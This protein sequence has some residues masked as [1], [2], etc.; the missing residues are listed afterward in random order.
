MNMK[1]DYKDYLK[2]FLVFVLVIMIRVFV[3]DVITVEGISMYPT[4]NE[5]HDKVILEKYKQFT[6][7]YDR[8]DIVV[9]KLEN[10]NIIKR[11]IGLPNET[12]EIK[13]SDVYINGDLFEEPYLDDSIKT[14]P[15]MTI[16]I[17]SD[18]IFVMGDNRENS[19]DS[20]SI[21]AIK[22]DDIMGKSVYRF[23][24]KKMIFNDLN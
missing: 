21:G 11:V 13:N 16:K 8:G 19:L 9:V 20:R 24:L 10:R 18:S 22:I 5:Y 14:Y 17:P 3:I 6:D 23:N 2:I 1:K 4:L 15:D 7:N 12:I